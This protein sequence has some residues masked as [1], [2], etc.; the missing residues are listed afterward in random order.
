MFSS[1][2]RAEHFLYL[3]ILYFCE[4]LKSRGNHDL[5]MVALIA[6]VIMCGLKMTYQKQTGKPQYIQ[7]FS[8]NSVLFLKG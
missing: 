6:H 2:Q 8:P 5:L 4:S 7:L 1:F 3:N